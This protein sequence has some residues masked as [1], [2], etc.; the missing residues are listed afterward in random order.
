MKRFFPVT[1]LMISMGIYITSYLYA[2]ENNQKTAAQRMI[3]ASE[4]TLAPVYSP[5]A[6]YIVKEFDLQTKTGI[7]LDIGAGPGTLIVELCRRTNIHWVN[8][9]KNPCF[10]AYFYD[11]AEQ[12]NSSHRVSAIYADVHQ[13]PF[14][15][16]YADMIISRGS[17]HFWKDKVKAFGEIYRV[18]K[19]RCSAFIGRGFSENLPLKIAKQIRSTQNRMFRYT[20]REKADELKRIMNEL[21]IKYTVHN[22]GKNKPDD[23]NYGIWIEIKK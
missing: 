17:Y 21:G 14:R 8:V 20:F 13:L 9:D 12:N 6:E 2:N 7:G 4:G 16:N 22:P 10:F 23:V 15:D 5:L 11:L 3:R 19:P 1:I 18:L